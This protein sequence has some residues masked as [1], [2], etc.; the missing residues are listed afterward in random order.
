[1]TLTPVP[2]PPA[3]FVPPASAP[4]SQI[5]PV[6]A[7]QT[8]WVPAT[9]VPAAALRTQVKAPP[10]IADQPPLRA[11]EARDKLDIPGPDALFQLESES[12]LRERMRQ[13]ERRPGN[14]GRI[15]FPEEPVVATGTYPGRHW[16]RSYEFVEPNYV[17]YGRLFFEDLNTDRYGFGLG[18]VQPLVSTGL[19][20]LDILTLPYHMGTDPCR[21]YEC[22]AGYCLPGD[23]VPYLLYPPKL[24]VTGLTMEGLAVTGLSAAFP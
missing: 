4:P 13:E 10:P 11:P 12:R 18:V 3:A 22:N 5:T 15:F 16:K 2:K 1:L 8:G 17:C 24:S 21:H 14:V 6:A 9:K 20:Y 23:P 19:F 7:P